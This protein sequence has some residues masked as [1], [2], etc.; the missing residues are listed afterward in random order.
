[1]KVAIVAIDGSWT[2]SIGYEYAI[3]T[4]GA[5]CQCFYQLPNLYGHNNPQGEYFTD[6]KDVPH[7]Y[8][9]L[10]FAGTKLFHEAYLRCPELLKAY[11]G[12]IKVIPSGRYYRKNHE[13][14]NAAFKD[15]GVE[16]HVMPDLFR[17]CEGE[18]VPFYPPMELVPTFQA[19]YITVCHSPCNVQKMMTKGSHI[20]CPTVMKFTVAFDVILYTPWPQAIQ[21]KARC[22]IFID[23]IVSIRE[24]TGGIGK[25][26]LEAMSLGLATISSGEPYTSDLLPSPPVL[27]ADKDTLK[28]AL[29]NLLQKADYRRKVIEEQRSWA[30]EF[31]SYEF[32]GRLLMKG[33]KR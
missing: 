31:L 7:K 10:I 12:C 14:L 6:L 11:K 9:L 5:E 18:Q 27:W 26:G 29:I 24:Y 8:D 17:Y 23:Q 19:P 1:M 15:V 20:I 4:T 28:Y 22:H 13:M 32:A 2:A 16:L 30:R 3:N 25:S 21:R 33:G